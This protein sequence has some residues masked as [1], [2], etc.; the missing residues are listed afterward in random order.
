M[1]AYRSL[2]VRSLTQLGNLDHHRKQ[3]NTPSKQRRFIVY[4]RYRRLL[5]FNQSSKNH[6]SSYTSI[7]RNRQS[8]SNIF[9]FDIAPFKPD[10]HPLTDVVD[11]DSVNIKSSYYGIVQFILTHRYTDRHR[12]LVRRKRFVLKSL[13]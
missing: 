13:D 6:A 9:Q 10:T 7:Q 8:V 1:N 12:L 5:Y 4:S 3:Y 2:M 11:F